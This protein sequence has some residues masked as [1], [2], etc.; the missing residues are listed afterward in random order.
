MSDHCRNCGGP[1]ALTTYCSGCSK[2]ECTSDCPTGTYTM[3]KALPDTLVG[4][5][6][7]AEIAWYDN[8]DKDKRK[9]AWLAKCESWR[10]AVR[11]IYWGCKTCGRKPLAAD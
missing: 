1:I 4:I 3:A 8:W 11:R 6:Q 7:A 5:E 10:K 9:A 2:E